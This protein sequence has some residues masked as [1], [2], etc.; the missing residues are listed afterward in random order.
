MILEEVPVVLVGFLGS[1]KRYQWSVSRLKWFRMLQDTLMK[2][3]PT[4]RYQKS[5]IALK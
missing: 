3:W 4:R 2:L 5:I 1:L